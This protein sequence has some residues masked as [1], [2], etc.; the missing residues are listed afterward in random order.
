MGLCSFKSTS[1]Q[2]RSERSC[3]GHPQGRERVCIGSFFVC[4]GMHCQLKHVTDYWFSL[5]TSRQ[6]TSSHTS[7]SCVKKH[8]FRIFSYRQ[9]KNWAMRV[10]QNGQQ[11]V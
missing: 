6:L 11:V 2:A 5:R 7:P 10:P 1:G 8:K 4:R 9:K 3:K